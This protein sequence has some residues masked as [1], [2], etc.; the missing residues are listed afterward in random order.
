[1][2]KLIAYCL[3]SAD[4][5]LLDDPF[6]FHE[7]LDDAY[8][9]DRLGVFL[10]CEATLWGRTTY[11]RF[12]G[13]FGSIQEPARPYLV[14][15]KAMPKYVFSSKLK[16]AEWNATILRGDVV[17]EVT[18]LKQ[19]DGGPLLILGHGALG[20]TL[21]RNRLIDGFD[22]VVH[23]VMLGKGQPLLREGQAAKFKLAAVKSYSKLVKLS[24]EL[25]Y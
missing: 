16:A 18:K 5:V 7:Y 20:E 13:V 22:L 9:L 10:A 25:Q 14:R 24:Y 21:L 3:V 4:G 19:Q 2:R 8:L 17:D 23:P 6:P 15:L 12:A 1:M 11:E